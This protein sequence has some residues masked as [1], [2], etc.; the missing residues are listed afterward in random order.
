MDRRPV[1]GR[2]HEAVALQADGDTQNF[3]VIASAINVCFQQSGRSSTGL[4][5]PSVFFTV[6]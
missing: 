3:T 5:G 4:F 2:R 1:C 6:E